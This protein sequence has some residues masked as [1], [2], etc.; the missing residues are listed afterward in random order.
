MARVNPPLNRMD[1][2]VAA[3]YAPLV[4]PQPTNS[5][6]IGD[7]LKYMPKFTLEEDITIEEHL[8]SF[9]SYADNLNIENEDVWIWVFVQSVYGEAQKW[10]RIL[11]LGSI[12]GIE[13]LDDAF[14]RH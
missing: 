5:L 6:P 11:L 13:A 9:Y 10:F 7:Y 2:I 12:V 14:L 4:L 3:R 8:V 1:A